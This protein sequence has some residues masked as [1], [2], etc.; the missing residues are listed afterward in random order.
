MSKQISLQIFGVN[1]LKNLKK[2]NHGQFCYNGGIP[3][4]I[5]KAAAL[6]CESE[7]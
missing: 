2:N 6:N 3:C 4:A 1:A 7:I 5:S